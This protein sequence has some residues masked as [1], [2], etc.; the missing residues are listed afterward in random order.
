MNFVCLD[1]TLFKW[2]CQGAGLGV[3]R[4]TD[5]PLFRKNEG[6]IRLVA[7][8]NPPLLQCIP[9]LLWL[10]NQTNQDLP[11]QYNHAGNPHFL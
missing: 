10:K 8:S 9:A 11:A 7:P 2:F 3:I 6:I 5:F 4:D 1:S